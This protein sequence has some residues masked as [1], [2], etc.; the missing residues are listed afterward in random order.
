MRQ[1]AAGTHISREVSTSLVPA[2]G[3]THTISSA[4]GAEE[5]E[6]TA[7]HAA[8]GCTYI[9]HNCPTPPQRHNHA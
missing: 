3:C 2:V 8:A 6:D 9:Q 1:R 5:R 7:W 4:A